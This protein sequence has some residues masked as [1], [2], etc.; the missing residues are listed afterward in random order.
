M[1]SLCGGERPY[2]NEQ[3][4]ELEQSRIQE[5]SWSKLFLPERLII[6]KLFSS[7]TELD[8]MSLSGSTVGVWQSE[9]VGWGWIQCQIQV[10]ILHIQFILWSLFSWTGEILGE[11]SK[12][13]LSFIGTSFWRRWR[14]HSVI[15]GWGHLLEQS[16]VPHD[17]HLQQY[18]YALDLNSNN[19][20]ASRLTT[21]RRTFSRLPTPQSP[22][23]SCGPFSTFSHRSK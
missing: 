23:S 15:L 12:L 3:V 22:F 19:I 8:L 20:L 17:C 13:T 16:S 10:L 5:V 9:K 11:S 14:R 4:L 21:I 6:L 18:F 7:S 2:L 1:E